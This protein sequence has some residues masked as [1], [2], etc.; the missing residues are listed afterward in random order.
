MASGYF[1]EDGDAA[2]AVI[3]AGDYITLNVNYMGEVK[4]TPGIKFVVEGA[5]VPIMDGIEIDDYVGD[6]VTEDK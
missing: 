6:S 5:R 4:P 3:H 1:S 2:P